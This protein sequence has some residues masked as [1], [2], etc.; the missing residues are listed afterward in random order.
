MKTFFSGLKIRALIV[1]A[2]TLFF[3]CSLAAQKE[4]GTLIINLPGSGSR[5]RATKWQ[6]EYDEGQF[7]YFKDFAQTLKFERILHN[8]LR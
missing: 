2:G 8:Q 6:T 7:P 3:S 1:C 5:V 4:Y